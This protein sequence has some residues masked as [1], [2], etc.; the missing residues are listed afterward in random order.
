MKELNNN[1]KEP[2]CSFEIS[3]LLKEK[4]FDVLSTAFYHKTKKELVDPKSYA[5]LAIN[6]NSDFSTASFIT[7]PTQS[8]ALE[9]I[10]VNF[11]INIES[12]VV[13]EKGYFS[14]TVY[15]NGAKKLKERFDTPQEAI[16]AGLLYALTKLIH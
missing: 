10:R 4:G 1:I 6:K 7:A 13:G 8:I 14:Y 15:I 5:D 3:N 11:D 16:E 12:H 2:I 9:W